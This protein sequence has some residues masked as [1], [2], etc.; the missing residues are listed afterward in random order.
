MLSNIFDGYSLRREL[1]HSCSID[2]WS[3]LKIRWELCILFLEKCAGTHTKFCRKFPENLE[4]PESLW[5]TSI[6][7]KEKIIEKQLTSWLRTV[8][9]DKGR[10][11][12]RKGSFPFWARLGLDFL[13]SLL[14]TEALCNTDYFS[15]LWTLVFYTESL[16]NFLF[17]IRNLFYTE[18]L[19]KI[20]TRSYCWEVADKMQAQS[21][22]SI[23]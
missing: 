10:M 16:A 19:R 21:P 17:S 14:F 6:P 4:L 7:E 3:P 11:K 20:S 8:E 12:S 9:G 1:Q 2:S 18:S 5:I 15:I 22:A 23:Y 13:Y